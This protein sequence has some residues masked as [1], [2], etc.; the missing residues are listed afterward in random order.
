MTSLLD[1][2]C[3]TSCCKRKI[4]LLETVLAQ[5]LLQLLH[6]CT[7]GPMTLNMFVLVYFCM[8][9][10]STY[11]STSNYIRMFLIEV[12]F[13]FGQF[14]QI[15]FLFGKLF[16]RVSK[17]FPR[18][19]TGS[20]SSKTRGSKPKEEYYKSG[21]KRKFVLFLLR[22]CY[23]CGMPC[24]F[25]IHSYQ[26]H[27][28]DTKLSKHTEVTDATIHLSSRSEGEVTHYL[29]VS[30]KWNGL[31]TRYNMGNVTTRTTALLHDQNGFLPN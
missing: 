3:S 21:S 7:L 13:K 15:P 22:N 29:A 6:P 20:T 2:Y 11:R 1:L 18:K 31:S 12:L 23:L 10:M 30:M 5:K 8:S 4:S 27:L 19:W 14:I 9:W 17:F 28:R 26:P 25:T 16:P 24:N